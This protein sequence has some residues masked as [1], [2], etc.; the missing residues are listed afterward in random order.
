MT[1]LPADGRLLVLYDADCGICSRSARLLRRLDHGR[2]LRLMPL[3]EAGEI[4]GAPP[5]EVLLDAMHVRD[6]H[7]RWSVAGGA[8]IR[9]AE[10]IPFLR[11]LAIGARL[12]LVRLFVEWA[13]ARVASNRHRL[14]R[15]LGDD[16]CPIGPRT[17]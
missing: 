1:A 3:Q 9:I 4:V 14:S 16:T 5:V 2:R 8:W 15:V 17:P 11:P 7:G 10:E 13:Y 12:A 6:R